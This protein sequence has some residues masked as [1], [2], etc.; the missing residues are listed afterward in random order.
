VRWLAHLFKAMGFCQNEWMKKTF[1]HPSSL[2]F[3]ILLGLSGLS[4]AQSTSNQEVKDI[5]PGLWEIVLTPA[6]AA[7]PEKLIAGIATEGAKNCSFSESSNSGGVA[8]FSNSCTGSYGIKTTGSLRFTA[9]TIDGQMRSIA[10][11]AG[12]TTS[13]DSKVSARWLGAC[14]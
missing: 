10:T 3:V 1:L 9:T 4:H 2:A 7:R 13:F 12:Q 6:D 11:V 8:K 14:R 5:S